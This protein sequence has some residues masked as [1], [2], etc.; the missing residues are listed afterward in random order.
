LDTNEYSKNRKLPSKV[1]LKMGPLKKRPVNMGS[2]KRH[3]GNMIYAVDLP[4]PEFC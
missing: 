3:P 4:R 2:S 1:P